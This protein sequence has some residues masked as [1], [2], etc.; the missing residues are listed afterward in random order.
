MNA[1]VHSRLIALEN[2]V[3]ELRRENQELRVHLGGQLQNLVREATSTIQSSLRM[4]HDGKDGRDGVDGQSIVG[5]QGPAGDV[6]YIGPE[7]VAAEVKKVRAEL[8]RVRA[9]FVGRILQGIADN[10]ADSYTQG[11]FRKHLQSILRDIENL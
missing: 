5:P 8:L 3:K 10:K 6:L 11:H 7:E 9:A 1:P 2:A 4:P